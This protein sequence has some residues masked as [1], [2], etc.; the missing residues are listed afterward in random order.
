MRWLRSLG[1]LA[2]FTACAC[3]SDGNVDGSGGDSGDTSASSSGGADE[4]STTS[5]IDEPDPVV[6]WPTLDCD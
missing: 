1:L 4:S 2:L 5:G 3:A 6:D